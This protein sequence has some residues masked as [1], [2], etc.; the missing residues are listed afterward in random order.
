MD[1]IK[2]ISAIDKPLLI[3]VISIIIC[4]L[5]MVASASID[6]SEK[7]FGSPFHFLI[8][9]MIFLLVALGIA[10]IILRT[11]MEKIAWLSVHLFMASVVL[12]ILVLIPH[13]GRSINGSSR[14]IGVGSVGLQVS[15]FAKLA[16]ILY[17]SGYLV[18]RNTQIQQHISGFIRPLCVL[19]I[20]AFLLLKEPDF[21]AAVVIISTGM[22]MMLLAG[23]PIRYFILLLFM[24][25]GV[26]ALL[27]IE[28]PY[29][30]LRLTSFMHPWE[31]QYGSSYQLTQSL[32]AFGNG[33]LFGVGL[34]NSIQ[35]LFYLPE[36][37]TDFL[38]AVLAEE[39]G[40][41]GIS[42]IFICYTLIVFRSMVIAKRAHACAEYYSS[43][44]ACGIGTWLGLQFLINV[45][46]NSG[47]LPTKGL[48]L[49][50]MSY[51][52]SSLLIDICALAI[53]FRI[54]YESR[55]KSI[56]VGC[57]KLKSFR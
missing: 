26:F 56:R 47:V 2:R 18:R 46:V 22:A 15:E 54:D 34:G 16:M 50:L 31:N 33:G 19:G 40:L 36:A 20:I 45:G 14:W 39:V 28:S 44:V 7:Q 13:I 6:V 52:G 17:L 4:G 57:G 49:P 30:L 32:I 9:Q 38:F 51:G 10:H 53:L 42:I 21:G 3:S 23:M 43:F 41:F 37:Q 1:T 29:R 55:L 25:G 8:R 24:V 12:L 35:K 11:S 5:V 27:A 48:T